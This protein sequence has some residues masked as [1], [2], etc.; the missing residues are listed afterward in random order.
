MKGWRGR[1]A[2]IPLEDESSTLKLQPSTL[3]PRPS[4]LGIISSTPDREFHTAVRRPTTTR[5]RRRQHHR[6]EHGWGYAESVLEPH[7]SSL[8]VSNLGFFVQSLRFRF[9]GLGFRV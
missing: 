2:E 1:V 4:T 3:D 6:S 7:L 9:Q 8:H 5:G